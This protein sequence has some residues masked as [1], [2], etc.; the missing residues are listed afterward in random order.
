M[1]FVDWNTDGSIAGSEYT[2]SPGFTVWLADSEVWRVRFRISPSIA[3]RALK[4]SGLEEIA[5]HLRLDVLARWA[6][7][8]LR[9]LVS[10]GE[11][12]LLETDDGLPILIATESDLS[13][14]ASVFALKRCEYLISNQ[15]RDELCGAAS[16]QDGDAIGGIGV[17]RVAPTSRRVCNSCGV[18]SSEHL[19]SS[20]RHPE[21]AAEGTFGSWKRHLS[22]ALCDKGMDEISKPSQCRA[23][24]NECWHLTIDSGLSAIDP[25]VNSVRLAEEIDFLDTLW[26]LR[27]SSSGL[28]K[29]RR[30]TDV[31]E[32]NSICATREDFI[33]HIGAL[34]DIINGFEVSATLLPTNANEFAK[35]GSLKKIESVLTARVDQE[36]I[37]QLERSLEMLNGLVLI[38][39]GFQHSDANA[40]L[41]RGLSIFGLP[42]PPVDWI[43]A[44]NLVVNR[45]FESIHILRILVQNLTSI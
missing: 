1:R 14:I 17:H 24:G 10:S 42:S 27:F 30:L 4:L 3:N 39:N 23:G 40:K 34:A 38:R 12:G 22:R 29:I 16:A 41:I 36:S 5:D 19:C 33:R 13:S 15:G 31:V 8:R 25:S 9:S 43:G 21:V 2:W 45:V 44:W 28:L 6:A 20:F 11:I 32:L 18:P 35:F 7:S 37:S 26:Q